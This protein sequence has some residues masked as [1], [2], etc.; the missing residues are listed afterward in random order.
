MMMRVQEYLLYF[1]AII[2]I[3]LYIAL[4]WLIWW[5]FNG[6]ILWRNWLLTYH[7][8]FM[9]FWRGKLDY[10]DYFK[11]NIVMYHFWFLAVFTLIFVYF[12]WCVLW[13]WDRYQYPS[14]AKNIQMR[15]L[16]MCRTFNRKTLGADEDEFFC[17]EHTGG[18]W[19]LQWLVMTQK[20]IEEISNVLCPDFSNLSVF[21]YHYFIFIFATHAMWKGAAL[22]FRSLSFRKVVYDS[23][24]VWS[25][26]C[27]SYNASQVD[28]LDSLWGKDALPRDLWLV[29]G[30]YLCGDPKGPVEAFIPS[31][32]GREAEWTDYCQ[33][34]GVEVIPFR[35]LY[36]CRH[37]TED[38]CNQIPD[39]PEDL[40]MQVHVMSFHMCCKL[41]MDTIKEI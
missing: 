11:I 36:F 13:L 8:G 26:A 5:Y 32:W 7:V 41:C 4:A 27:R 18:T 21:L 16:R 12:K 15:F 22:P 14:E 10:N 25:Y 17:N 20:C 28:Y 34:A 35:N 6:G 38:L 37:H 24:Q 2:M 33:R 40:T 3:P 31:T 1:F 9:Y 29:V 30:E 23:N 19:N 39:L